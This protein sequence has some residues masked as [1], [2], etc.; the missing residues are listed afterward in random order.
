MAFLYC[1]GEDLPYMSDDS[2]LA[3]STAKETPPIPPPSKTWRHIG[4]DLICD[5]PES[6]EG[7]KHILVTVCYLSKYVAVRPLK[8]KT[9]QE[10]IQNLKDIYLDMGLPYIIQHDQ[11]KE[12]TSNVS[13]I[14]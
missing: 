5:L 13:S 3:T 6:E 1:K 7:Y 8:T 12:F 11:G 9:S 14:L 2:G 10:V 4:M